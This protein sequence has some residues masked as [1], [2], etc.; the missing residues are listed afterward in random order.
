MNEDYDIVEMDFPDYEEEYPAIPDIKVAPADM[1]EAYRRN[2]ELANQFSA[3]SAEPAEKAEPIPR[4]E[5][6]AKPRGMKKITTAAAVYAAF[7]IIVAAAFIANIQ[8]PEEIGGMNLTI[9]TDYEECAEFEQRLESITLFVDED[10]Q[11]HYDVTIGFTMKNIS[12]DPVIFF[13]KLLYAYLDNLSFRS[14]VST[15]G[16][17]DYDDGVFVVINDQKDFTVTYRLDKNEVS[18][19]NC[20]GYG[21]PY[22]YKIDI[23]SEIKEEIAAFLSDEA[24]EDIS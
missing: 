11:R 14:P 16:T 13:P 21:L 7:L 18:Q 10:G 24:P 23:D 19:I 2:I 8:K 20:F 9:R 5:K 17:R 3:D 22:R 4:K 1:D 6:A 15:E 12:D